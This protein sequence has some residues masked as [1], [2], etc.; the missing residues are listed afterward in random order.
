MI[1]KQ[2]LKDV[3]RLALPAVGEMILYML[4]WV[5][6]TMMVGHY[7]G[8]LTVTAVSLSSET[9]YTFV[10][11]FIAS[12]IAVG[13]TSIIARKYGA[14]KYDEVQTFASVAITLSVFVALFLSVIFFTFPEQILR[15]AQANDDIIALGAPYI[16]ICS[17]GLFFHMIMATCN[18]VLRGTGNTF[19]PLVASAVINCVNIFLDWT[20]IFGKFGMPELGV[21]GA[22]LATAT[23]HFVGFLFIMYYMRFKFEFNVKFINLA[24]LKRQLKDLVTLSIPSGMQEAAFS[25]CRLIN[26]FM[27]MVLGSAAFSANAITTTIESISFMPGYGLAVAA[28]TLVGHKYGEKNYKQAQEYIKTCVL[29]GCIIM[30]T[31]A[32]AFLI[33]PEIFIRAFIKSD[34]VEVIAYGKLCL[35][36]AAIEQIPMAVSMILGGSLKGIGDTKTPFKVALFTNWAIRLPLI[37]YFIIVLRSSVATVWIITAFQWTIDATLMY[38]LYKKH[39][40]SEFLRQESSSATPSL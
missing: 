3:L 40:R 34:E 10:N 5:F 27:I 28:T 1:K 15:L 22:A 24:S 33:F 32:I 21:K 16:K 23:A 30:G 6:D 36:I 14:K 19:V 8:K 31:L 9:L 26:T 2:T 25:V 29:L 38:I 11:I 17:V 20:L 39:L 12:G 37:Y 4:I 35:R 13:I 7:G 18:G